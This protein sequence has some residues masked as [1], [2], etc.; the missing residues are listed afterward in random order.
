MT[1]SDHDAKPKATLESRLP[2][3]SGPWANAWCLPQETSTDPEVEDRTTFEGSEAYWGSTDTTYV[4]V[5][6]A[7]TP[8]TPIE[9]EEPTEPEE[10]VAPLISTEIAIITAVAIIGIVGVAAYY[11]IRKR[12]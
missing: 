4:M 1:E 8:S 12:Q 6:E 3:P 2:V 11:L 9:P 5:N 7:A 10:P